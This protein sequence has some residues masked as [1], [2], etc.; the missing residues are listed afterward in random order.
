MPVRGG[1][2]HDVLPE[3]WL[4]TLAMPW[5]QELRL[6]RADGVHVWDDDSKRYV[7]LVTNGGVNVLGHAHPELVAAIDAQLRALP[8]A[9]ADFA[10]DARDEFIEALSVAMPG[11][12]A[13][14]AIT[15]SGSEAVD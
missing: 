3:R 4:S 9:H 15:N 12:F 11:G 10:H 1:G 5:S 7:D 14:V 2:A 13:T 6:V 8:S